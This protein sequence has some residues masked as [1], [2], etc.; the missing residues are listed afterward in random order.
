MRAL[1]IGGTGPTG[2]YMV[3]GLLD[4]GY[5]VAMLHSGKLEIPEIPDG[6]EHLHTDAYN[7]VAL[8]ETLAGREFELTVANYGR[9]RAIAA[10]L[11]CVAFHTTQA[12]NLPQVGY[13]VTADQF[14]MIAY[15]VVF[16]TLLQVVAEHTLFL[17][18]NRTLAVRLDRIARGV[19]PVFFFGLTALVIA[20][21]L[22]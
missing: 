19:Y 16:L 5:Q 1:V 21:S 17:M 3:N 9:L 22:P 18:G 10:L 14:F 4:R 20:R 2:H 8:E 11:A 6:V 13:V 12:D 7:R 15:A